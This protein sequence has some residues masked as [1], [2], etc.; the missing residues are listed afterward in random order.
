M[1]W[2]HEK[3]LHNLENFNRKYHLRDLGVDFILILKWILVEMGCE[4]MMWIEVAR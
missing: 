2:E 3:C 4:N 1:H